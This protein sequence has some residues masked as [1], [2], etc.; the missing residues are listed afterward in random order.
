[1]KPIRT[2]VTVILL[3]SSTLGL[4]ACGEG[5]EPQ[6]LRGRV[7]YTEERTAGPGVEYVRAYML[8]EKGPVL[9]PETVPALKGTETPVQDA[10]PMFD[11]GQQKAK[12]LKAADPLFEKSQQKK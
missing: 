1:M 7:P 8:P 4:A 11:A 5:W 12:G 3:G 6:E 9:E 10:E 2:A